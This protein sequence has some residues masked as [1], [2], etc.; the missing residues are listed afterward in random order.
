MVAILS[1]PQCDIQVAHSQCFDG[2]DKTEKI[3]KFKKIGNTLRQRQNGQHL[4]NGIFKCTFFNKNLI[5]TKISLMF[6]FEGP[7]DNMPVLV[8]MMVW[9]QTCNKSLSEPMMAYYTDACMRTWPWWVN[10][11]YSEHQLKLLWWNHTRFE[12]SQIT[13]NLTVCSTIKLCIS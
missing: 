12:V 10:W 11:L 8:Q 7:N 6:V 1:R 5:L 2:S 3:Y 4:A 9:R 13:G